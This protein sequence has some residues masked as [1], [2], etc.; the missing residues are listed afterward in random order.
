MTE[1]SATSFGIYAIENAYT[2]AIYVGGTTKSFDE[3]WRAHRNG[4][5][6]GSHHSQL[7]QDAWNR[8][9]ESVFV[10]RILEVV[11]DRLLVPIRERQWMEELQPAYNSAYIAIGYG[12]ENPQKSSGV[13]YRQTISEALY[14]RMDQV[15]GTQSVQDF[16]ANA[17]RA[18]VEGSA[19]E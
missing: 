17:I 4:L 6:N 14:A 1:Q 13:T 7:L 2:G 19:T 15:R 11:Q 10:F 12:S 3:R 18:A 9:G 5:N 8:H 16:T